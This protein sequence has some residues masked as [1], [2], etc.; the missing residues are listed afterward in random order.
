MKNYID[1]PFE[2]SW[3]KPGKKALYGVRPCD[4]HSLVLLDKAIKDND[5]YKEKRDNTL[6][7]VEGC[8]MPLTT[9]FC[10]SVSS[11]PFSNSG[12]D[13]F[14]TDIGDCYVV[15]DIS[16]RGTEYVR[17]LND[18]DSDHLLPKEETAA[19]SVGAIEQRIN[20]EGMSEKL[21]LV[22]KLFETN[23]TWQRLGDHCTNCTRCT[24][25]C[26][27][28]HCCFVVED[29][30]EIVCDHF[31]KGAKDFDPCM[32]NIFLSEGLTGDKPKGHKRLQRRLMDKFCRTMKIVGQP[33]CVGCGRCITNCAE[34]IDITEILKIVFNMGN[35]TARDIGMHNDMHR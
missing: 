4:A 23:D 2:E 14:M 8:N 30:F 32:L 9:C 5:A 35:K 22:D 15:E 12:A 34:N 24:S 18:A 3:L 29:V 10:T 19:K 28:C 1:Y 33:F 7:I 26:P 20:F 25:V 13:I 21:E 31:G 6:I 11:G 16:G 17:Q 27:T